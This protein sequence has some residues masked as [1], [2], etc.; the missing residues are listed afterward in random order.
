MRRTEYISHINSKKIESEN[1]FLEFFNPELVS[2][3]QMNQA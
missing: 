3:L 1:K 2:S